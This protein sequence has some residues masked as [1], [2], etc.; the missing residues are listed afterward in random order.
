M[1]KLKGRLTYANV[2]STLCLFLLLGGGAYAA[3]KL[4]RNSVGTRQL[5]KNAVSAPKLRRN[6]VTTAK[7][8]NGAITQAKLAP[9]TLT[10]ATVLGTPEAWHVVGAPGEPQFLNGWKDDA[11]A[12][13]PSVAF[14]RDPL[15]VVHL[16]GHASGPEG[17]I[18]FDLP[19][20]F[21]P[22]SGK[23]LDLLVFCS[24]S[25]GATSGSLNVVGPTGE[26]PAEYQGALIPPGKLVSLDGLSFR[27]EG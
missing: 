16:R 21:R 23:I 9:G 2:V 10:T 13:S 17:T 6:A 4:P 26:L 24:C 19:P 14:Y 12:S 5:K 27:A 22:E 20:G 7:V 3:I 8:K 15:D 1:R 18:M 11:A 25:G